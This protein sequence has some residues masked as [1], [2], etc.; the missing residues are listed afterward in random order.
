MKFHRD[1]CEGP[2]A[3]VISSL[4]PSANGALHIYF[5]AILQTVYVDHHEYWFWSSLSSL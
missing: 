1:R 5:K 4:V 3:E 2:L